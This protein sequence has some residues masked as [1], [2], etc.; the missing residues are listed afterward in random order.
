MKKLFFTI[1]VLILSFSNTK[2]F[3]KKKLDLFSPRRQTPNAILFDNMSKPDVFEKSNNLTKRAG[4]FNVAT[5]ETLYIEGEITDAFGVQVEGAIIKIWQTN[6]SGHYHSLLSE[7]SQYIDPNFLMSGGA[8][9]NNLG[10]YGF[11]TIFPGFYEE[12][13]PHINI[14]IVHKDFGT[15]ETEIYFDKHLRNESDP[16]YLS[17][18]KKD[19]EMLTA[20]MSYMNPENHEEGKNAIFNITME[21]IHQYKGF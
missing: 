6:A 8:V 21:G 13:A 17:Y 2:A 5:G 11:L 19:R 16:Q 15:I 1:A 18:S 7:G 14:M 9:S 10:R 12:R 20:K 4:S 3:A